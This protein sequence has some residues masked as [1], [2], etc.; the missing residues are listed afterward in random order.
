MD[1]E[2]Q[3]VGSELQGVPLPREL[4][5]EAFAVAVDPRF[6]MGRGYL[7]NRIKTR[8]LYQP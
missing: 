3:G 2:V 6:S 4:D 8:K 1:A 7:A 5:T